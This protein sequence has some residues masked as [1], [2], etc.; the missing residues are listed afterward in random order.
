MLGALVLAS[1]I[2][3]LSLPGVQL[4]MFF[5]ATFTLAYR[6]RALIPIYV[7]VLLYLLYFGFMP[8]NIPYLYI[9]LPLWGLFMGIGRVFRNK[10]SEP[11]RAVKTITSMIICGLFGLAF[12]TLYAPFWAL[13]AGLSFKQTVAWIIAGFPVDL[14]YAVSN[15]AF[16]IMI[17]PLSEL[18]IKLDRS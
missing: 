17:V 7:Y 4:V 1:Q 18:L 9:W 15:F 11:A 13:I 10:T 3:T 2:V 8:W 6:W 14:G 5:I 12:G 16:G